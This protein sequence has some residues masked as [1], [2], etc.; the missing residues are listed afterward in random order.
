MLSG[1][2]G[3]S[4]FFSSTVSNTE[5]DGVSSP[6]EIIVKPKLHI[7]KRIATK[8][9]AFVIKLPAVL[10]NMKLSW[11]TPIPKAPPSD[12]WTNTKMT[13]IS[14]NI[15]LSTS[16]IFSMIVNYMFFLLYQ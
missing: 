7:I 1:I 9:V 13:Y 5:E 3:V 6:L 12:F 8:L 16:N 14:A 15:I 11:D 2:L 4:S 10:E